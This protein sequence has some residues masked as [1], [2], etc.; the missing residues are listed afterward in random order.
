MHRNSTSRSI[1]G[2]G[3]LTYPSED[4]HLH[5][6]PILW[7]W[8]RNSWRSTVLCISFLTVLLDL[9]KA[10]WFHG[11]QSDSLCLYTVCKATA[12]TPPCQPWEP[13]VGMRPPHQCLYS[14]LEAERNQRRVL[15]NDVELFRFE[16]SLP[17]RGDWFTTWMCRWKGTAISFGGVKRINV[18]GKHFQSAEDLPVSSISLASWRNPGRWQSSF[19]FSNWL[20]RSLTLSL[21]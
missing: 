5:L 4:T 10:L 1:D 19:I 20:G 7:R 6:Q 11:A 16:I 17:N 14:R 8:V 12:C 9:S 13:Y 21:K 2:K 15:Q 18:E 3:P